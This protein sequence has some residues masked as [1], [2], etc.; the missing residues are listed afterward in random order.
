MKD[1][2]SKTKFSYLRA[3]MILALLTVFLLSSFEIY[4]AIASGMAFGL[5]PHFICIATL[6]G[7]IMG[8]FVT[9][10]LGDKIK[11][12]VARYRKPQVKKEN[13]KDKMFK[14]LWNR[15]GVFGV[16]FIG[17]FL[18]G[19]PASIGIGYGLGV[20]PKMLVNLCLLAVVI[21]CIVYSYFFD[22]V[23][24]IIA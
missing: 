15:Y 10:F 24:N 13:S 23:R 14:A 11:A 3:H 4:V 17:T 22:Y 20:Q 2:I 9:A 8:V 1:K 12:L 16:G 18:L 21:R 6:A 7:G 5:S 19:A